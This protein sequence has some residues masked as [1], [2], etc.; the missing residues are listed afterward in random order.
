[1]QHWSVGFKVWLNYKEVGADTVVIPDHMMEADLDDEETG[2]T[3]A[4]AGGGNGTMDLGRRQ[5]CWQ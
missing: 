4:V 1:M 5:G 2:K 3:V